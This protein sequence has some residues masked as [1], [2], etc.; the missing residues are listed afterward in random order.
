MPTRSEILDVLKDVQD[1]ELRMSIVELGLVYRAE[2]TG[3]T[4]EVD[5][6]LTYP[7]CPAGEMIQKD[8]VEKLQGTFERDVAANL[9]WS[10]RWDPSFMTDEAKVTL[11]YPV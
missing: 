5:F 8:I 7:G 6:T 11:G 3:G 10:P 9:V 4:I 1:P 2:E